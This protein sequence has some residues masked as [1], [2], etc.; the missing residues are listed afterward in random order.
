MPCHLNSELKFCLVQGANHSIII[1]EKI[2]K[3]TERVAMPGYTNVDVGKIVIK[4]A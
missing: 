2:I 3:G 1:C 4:K